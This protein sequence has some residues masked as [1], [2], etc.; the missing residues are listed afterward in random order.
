VVDRAF[1]EHKL[2]PNIVV[3]TEDFASELSAVRAGLGNTIMNIG[4]LPAEGFG[5][6]APPLPVEPALYMTCSVISNSDIA[7]TMAA[8]AVQ[9]SLI[10]VVRKFVKETKRRGARLMEA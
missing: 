9:S 1:A 6:L 7:L 4:E 3:E 8:E 5:G 10:E 2:V